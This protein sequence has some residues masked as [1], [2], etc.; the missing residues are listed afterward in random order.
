[1][2]FNVFYKAQETNASALYLEDLL[3]LHCMLAHAQYNYGT[4]Q[5]FCLGFNILDWRKKVFDIAIKICL[6]FQKPLF[7]NVLTMLLSLDLSFYLSNKKLTDCF[8]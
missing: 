8:K 7:L 6:L 2:Q 1:M 4:H 5:L 3:V